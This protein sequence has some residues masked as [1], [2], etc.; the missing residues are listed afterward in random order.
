MFGYSETCELEG[1]AMHTGQPE[2]NNRFN[3][4]ENLKAG[5]SGLV[6]MSARDKKVYGDYFS[7]SGGQVTLRPFHGK[8]DNPA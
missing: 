7:H 1:I 4:G 6:K 8:V 3:L 5:Q 2:S